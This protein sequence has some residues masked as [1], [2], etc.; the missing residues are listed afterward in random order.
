MY[1][2]PVSGSKKAKSAFLRPAIPSYNRCFV[3]LFEPV[4]SIWYKSVYFISPIDK[5][6][7]CFEVSL[8]P[9]LYVCVCVYLHCIL[10]KSVYTPKN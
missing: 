9:F 1:F 10:T 2:R 8:P 6:Y 4:C 3:Y 5:I 7:I